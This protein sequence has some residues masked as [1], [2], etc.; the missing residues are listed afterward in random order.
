MQLQIKTSHSKM[1]PIE[2][3]KYIYDLARCSKCQLFILLKQTNKL[4]GTN[5]D[6]S[7]IH[8]IDVPFI[9]NSDLVFKSDPTIKD[10]SMKYEEFFIPSKYDWVIVPSIYWD[11]YIGGDI[12]SVY[13]PVN[14][15]FILLDKTTNQPIE[16]IYMGICRERDDF[17]RK[18]FIA[19]LEGF[20]NRQATLGQPYIFTHM[21]QN[22]SIRKSYDNKKSIGRVLCNLKTDIKDVAFY[23]Y[24]GLFSLAKSD[25]L[26][27]E[28]RFDII[29][30]NTFMVSFKPKKK[31]NPLMFNTYGV[32]FN[33]KIHCMYINII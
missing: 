19:Q 6:C 15:N 9:V 31:K 8:E 23:F 3:F 30:S 25:T 5:E 4:Y 27:L 26:D 14:N 7:C 12:I 18:N 24:K 10:I 28:I 16:C 29:Q 20:L 33:E 1:I 32:P 13:S 2:G 21:E 22:E 17:Y 11:M